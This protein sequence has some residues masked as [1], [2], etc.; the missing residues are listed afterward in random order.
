MVVVV[1]LVVIVLGRG[2]CVMWYLVLG[3]VCELRLLV[4]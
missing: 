1:V 4:C 2:F 3:S